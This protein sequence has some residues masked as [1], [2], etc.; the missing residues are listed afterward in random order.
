MALSRNTSGPCTG[1]ISTRKET[2]RSRLEE[3]TTRGSVSDARL[4]HLDELKASWEKL[5]ELT[6]ER[7]VRVDTD[8]LLE[9]NQKTIFT[10]TATH[11]DC[12]DRNTT[13]EELPSDG[14]D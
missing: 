5:A 14:S 9:E 8:R 2:I 1:R 4:H 12:L 10:H 6:S 7:L 3:R 11:R 13:L